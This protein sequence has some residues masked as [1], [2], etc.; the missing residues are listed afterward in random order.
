MIS[1]LSQTAIGDVLHHG[2]YATTAFLASALSISACAKQ[3]VATKSSLTNHSV[4]A[5][6][7]VVVIPPAE[8]SALRLDGDGNAEALVS[9]YILDDEGNP[10]SLD[11]PDNVVTIP[12]EIDP[13]SGASVASV[14]AQLNT[15][16]IVEESASGAS[17][18]ID[19]VTEFPADPETG[20]PM[21]TV[22]TLAEYD[23]P[24][25]ALA[26]MM[27]G[28]GKLDGWSVSAFQEV[29]GG[30][31]ASE[32][33]PGTLRP[34]LLATSEKVA[35]IPRGVRGQMYAAVLAGAPD[36][37]KMIANGEANLS[38]A[39]A[40]NRAVVT[41]SFLA[42]PGLQGLPES[43]TN[44]F[45][46]P[47]TIMNDDQVASVISQNENIKATIL[48]RTANA[49][50][51]MLRVQDGTFTPGPGRSFDPG[52][53]AAV[54]DTA[55]TM[56]AVAMV[57]SPSSFTSFVE[58]VR[59]GAGTGSAPVTASSIVAAAQTH[60][61]I[62]PTTLTAA[63]ASAATFF[64]PGATFDPRAMRHNGTGS[65]AGGTGSGTSA[66]SGSAPGSGASGA[67]GVGNPPPPPPPHG[68]HQGG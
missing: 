68:P 58:A 66:G 17:V 33:D 50:A 9:T 22:Q 8:S 20:E 10:S 53:L 42:K 59:E 2:K 55:Q 6:N 41:D 27:L 16:I 56:V 63:Q 7:V 61:D 12:V 30:L 52:Q 5:Y 14:P 38:T 39:A 34:I 18:V 1:N 57:A 31:K 60:A 45:R 65:A 19:P 37:P 49:A 21:T 24:I 54:K 32:T 36:Y 3:E 28:T 67:N 25:P 23:S 35:S 4:A 51:V 40:V 64:R 62:S 26:R 47:A 13:A 43:V 48:T 11:A 29:L 15:L 46:N 44:F